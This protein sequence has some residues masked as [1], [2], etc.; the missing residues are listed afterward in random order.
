MSSA[1]KDERLQEQMENAEAALKKGKWFEAERLAQRAMEMARRTEDFG[2]MARICLPLQEARRQ[3]VQAALDLKKIR[4]LHSGNMDEIKIESG[5]YLLMPM[6]LV[7][8]DARRLRLAALREEKPV[9]VLCC[10]PP[11]LRGKWPVVA[12]GAATVR[13][14][15]DPPENPKKPSMK[16]YVGAMEALGNAGLSGSHVDTGMDLD[17]Q[18]DAVLSLLDAV[19]DHER[20]HQVL[21]EMC[22]EA[23]KGFERSETPALSELDAEL[24]LEEETDIDK[25]GK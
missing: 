8:A 24:A 9:T 17:R 12:I 15:L 19:P 25:E 22:R 2:S 18:I 16:W 20:L 23:E 6:V 10:E 5:S 14:Y 3:R 4:I 13:A 11:N 7:G 1:K 21:A